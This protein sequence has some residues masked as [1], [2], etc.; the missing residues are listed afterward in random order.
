MP[1]SIRKPTHIS[2]DMEVGMSGN[3]WWSL[4]DWSGHHGTELALHRIACGFCEEEGNFQ[5]E[6]RASRTSKSRNKTLNYDIYR[7]NGCGNFTM[8]FWTGGNRCH[9]YRQVPWP[10]QT[11]TFPEHW[12][13]DVGRYWLQARRSLEGDNWD[14]AAVMARSGLQLLLRRDNA[15]GQTLLKE[16]DDL[17]SKGRIPPVVREWAHELRVLGNEAAHP[18]P[19]SLGV[20]GQDARRVVKFLRVL[21]ELLVD[22]PHEIAQYRSEKS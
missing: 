18:T 1:A 9:D 15:D 12:P 13:K 8:V 7:C 2:C 16:I 19:G 20:A 14:A 21:L 4:G 5:R 10:T 11:K 6:H 3:F 22:L 17:A